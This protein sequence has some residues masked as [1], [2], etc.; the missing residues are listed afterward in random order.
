M[1]RFL[2]GDW[3]DWQAACKRMLLL[4]LLLLLTAVV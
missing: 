3:I 4:L 1:R 2:D